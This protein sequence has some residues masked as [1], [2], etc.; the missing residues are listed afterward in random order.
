MELYLNF[1][2]RTFDEVYGHGLNPY[3]PTPKEYNGQSIST[4]SPNVYVHDCVFRSCTNTGNG[5]A[6]YCSGSV[7][8]LLVEQSS[9]ISCRTSSS[10]GGGI[11]FQNTN[12][13]E[14]VL[15]RVCG[16][17]CLTT[18]SGSRGQFA[19]IN[20]KIKNNVNDSS[21]THSYNTNSST[22]NTLRLEC[23]NILCPYVNITNNEC[24]WDTAIEF[25]P[26]VIT[27]TVTCC[28]SYSSIV[29]NTAR[30]YGIIVHQNSGSQVIDTCNILKNNQ[31][32]T[33]DG[34]IYTNA[35]LHIKDCCILGNGEGKVVFCQHSSSCIITISNCTIDDDIK[36]GRTY[37]SVTINKTI[38]FAFIHALS[39]IATQSCDSYFDSY[40]TLTAKPIVPSKKS[41]CLMSCICK[42]PMNYPFRSIEFLFLFLILPYDTTIYDIF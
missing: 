23:D 38:Q 10:N 28:I 7:I 30:S 9:F 15:C 5:G 1:P 14:C 13:G 20:T 11:F 25:F 24:Y 27:G 4:N 2:K 16:F 22:Q 12:N 36:S 34:I 17:D 19:R 8:K 42:H 31:G 39:H 3:I 18:T 32:G 40:G 35:N 41:L 26:K 21:F 37:G 33:S 29:N 6:L